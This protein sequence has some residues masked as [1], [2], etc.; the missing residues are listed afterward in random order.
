MSQ[1]GL[2]LSD[3]LEADYETVFAVLAANENEKSS[4]KLLTMEE[5][6][7]ANPNL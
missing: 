2:T 6:M 7:L 3:V 1:S 4:E 5:F